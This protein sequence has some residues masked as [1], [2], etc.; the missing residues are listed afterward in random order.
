MLAD[1]N[2]RLL[3]EYSIEVINDELVI[4]DEENRF[5]EYQPGITES[6]RVQEALFHE[7]RTIIENCLFGVDINPNSVKI[8]RLR[9]WIGLLKNACYGK[10]GMLETMLNIGIN[11]YCGNSL[12]STYPLDADIKSALKGS[13]WTVESYRMAVMRYRNASI[14]EEK[15][16]MERLIGT[17]TPLNGDLNSLKS[18]IRTAISVVLM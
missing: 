3:K 7:K 4:T 5:F 11:F 6:Q 1:R 18:P 8:C 9:L 2:G 12:I 13:K 17:I 14:R 16:E 15:R 10:T